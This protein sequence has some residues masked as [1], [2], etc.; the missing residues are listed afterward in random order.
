MDRLLPV[1]ILTAFIHMIITFHYSIRLAGL[2]TGRLFTAISI[3]NVVY[4]LASASNV[5]QAPLLTSVIEHAIKAGTMQAGVAPA[6]QLPCAETYKEQ[7]ILL[8]GKLRLVM[9]ASTAGTAAGALMI[10]AVVRVFIRAIRIFEEVGSVP[11]VFVRLFFSLPWRRAGA[12]LP[13]FRPAALLIK[14][15]MAIPKNILL[16]NIVVTGFY[17][18]GVLSALYAG[19]MFPDFRSTAT[20]LSVIVNGFAV[21]IGS[22]V[23][24]PVLSA[25][26]DQAMC[27]ARNETDIKQLTL[28]MALTR[29]LGTVFAQVF[30]LPCAYLVEYFARLLA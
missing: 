5:I 4:L 3:F 17:T 23:V 25:I 29:L 21:V 28:C 13:R 27:G 14:K 22:V 18:T 15:R 26:T 12:A 10:P 20:S 16:I 9:F 30:F 7:L 19:A 11:V 24:E 1:T 6:G 8:E 2:R